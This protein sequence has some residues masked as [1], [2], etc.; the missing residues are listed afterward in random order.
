MAFAE[1]NLRVIYVLLQSDW[2]AQNLELEPV[3]PGMSAQTNFSFPLPANFRTRM[4]LRG[5]IRL[6]RETS[7]RA[8]VCAWV[9]VCVCV[10]CCERACVCF[11]VCVCFRVC[12]CAYVF[13]HECVFVGVY[14][15]V[16]VCY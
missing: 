6:A 13:L 7:V 15:C 4:H 11:I 1:I 14:S 2:F 12:D 16:S 3:N 5:K 8:C 9:R 10:R